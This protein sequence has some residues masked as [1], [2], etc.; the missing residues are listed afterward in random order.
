MQEQ[1]T[2]WEPIE[3]LALKYYVEAITDDIEGG[4]KIILS[5]IN[6]RKNTVHVHFKDSAYAYSSAN[7]RFRRKTINTLSKHYGPDFHKWTFFK[8]TNSEYIKY[9][10]EESYGWSDVFGFIHFSFIAADSIVDV[11][12][13]YE[14]EVTIVNVP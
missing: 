10:S 12:D 14:P 1:W 4:F 8:V 9:L 3:G 2:R 5:N 13:N 11:I 7:E 6:N